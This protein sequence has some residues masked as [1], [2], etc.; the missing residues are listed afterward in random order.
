MGNNQ[1]KI[2][3]RYFIFVV[4]EIKLCA[5]INSNISFIIINIKINLK[6]MHVYD[7]VYCHDNIY[8]CP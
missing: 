4:A 8:D 7:N 6:M 2:F 1:P 5:L 3:H